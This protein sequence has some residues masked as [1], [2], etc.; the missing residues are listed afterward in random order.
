MYT[1][2]IVS[3][4][5]Y[6]MYNY[7]F[8]NGNNEIRCQSTVIKICKFCNIIAFYDM[9]YMTTYLQTKNIEGSK[10]FVFILLI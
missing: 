7:R 6:V 2:K 5:T 4:I 8:Q 9:C 1:H 10:V 3:V